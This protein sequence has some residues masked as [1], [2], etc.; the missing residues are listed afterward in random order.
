MRFSEYLVE[1]AVVKWDSRS[2]KV[3]EAIDL[4]NRH[5]KMGLKA[6]SSGGLLYRG[7]K[8][9]TKINSMVIN[10]STG[11]RTS[12]DTNNLYQLMMDNSKALKDYPK[13][14]KSLICSSSLLE[15]ESYGSA[16]V[17][18]P[19]DGTMVACGGEDDFI[20]T[21][22]GAVV[23]HQT[24]DDMSQVIETILG[25]I[26]FKI[27]RSGQ[28]RDIKVLND[29]VNDHKEEFIDEWKEYF[30]SDISSYVDGAQPFTSLSSKLMTPN[31]LEIYLE[32]FGD[33]LNFNIECWFSGPC[34]AID[35][36]V[37]AEILLALK[38]SN[39]KIHKRIDK[40]FSDL[41]VGK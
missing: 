11:E 40:E 30:G 28:F 33:E 25:N 2:V 4:L 21:D 41:Y 32:K 39:H 18:V 9:G 35:T 31:N 23:D 20:S 19:F 5:C 17:I 24:L 37:F 6:I 22:I 36:K 10:P 3:D 15:A 1:K 27:D 13:R 29:F 34:V 16:M 26:G 12:K 14:G 38:D 8:H 7:F